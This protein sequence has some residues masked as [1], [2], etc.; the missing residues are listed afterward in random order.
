MIQSF[1]QESLLKVKALDEGFPLVQ[2][3][4]APTVNHS[5]LRH[6]T[7]SR[8]TQSDSDPHLKD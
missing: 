4:E 6:L 8:H 2:L 1:S 7:T 3:I 5:R